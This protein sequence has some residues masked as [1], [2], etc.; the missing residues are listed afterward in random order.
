MR[1]T[2]LYSVSIAI[3]PTGP[4][5]RITIYWYTTTRVRAR[6]HAQCF[7]PFHV[8]SNLKLYHLKR[9]KET[10]IACDGPTV[11][12]GRRWNVVA[13]ATR[14]RMARGR[15]TGGP[16]L[17]LRR[18]AAECLAKRANPKAAASTPGRRRDVLPRRH[19][20]ERASIRGSA[21]KKIR[22]ET[23][24]PTAMGAESKQNEKEDRVHG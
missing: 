22:K 11:R 15:T 23:P 20:P 6:S 14:A 17:W 24:Q 9:N 12:P 13:G 19:G 3:V 8:S 4:R 18:A 2:G 7:L 10:R 1:A 5:S 21:G 16:A